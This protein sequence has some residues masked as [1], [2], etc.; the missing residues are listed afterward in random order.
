[1][2]NYFADFPVVDYRFGD[3]ETFTKFQHL[4]TAV[5]ILEQV[6][7]YEVYYETY[8]IQNGERPEV[9][10]YKLYE[11]TNFYWTFY[12]LNDHLRQSGWPLRDAAVWDYVQIYYPNTVI[13]TPAVTQP[14]TPKLIDTGNEILIQWVSSGPQVPL[15][16]SKEFVAGGYLWFEFSKQVGK[17]IRVDH[18]TGF[19]FTDAKD[20]RGTGVEPIVQVISKDDYELFLGSNGEITPRSPSA[21]AEIIKTY[22]EYDAPHHWEDTEGNW[23]YPTPS[24]VYPY[25][26]DH[27]KLRGWS[28]SERKWYTASTKPSVNSVSYGQKIVEL[29]ERQKTISVI[30]RDSIEQVVTEFNRL[31]RQ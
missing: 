14:K 24:P 27:E 22:A 1:M 18:Q 2:S 15:A 3:E 30:K 26:V 21:E 13:V 11:D 16:Q 9:L 5:D 20:I 23:I 12:L 7:Q 8:E 19:I 4:G 31:L 6:K 29:N 28:S 17:I 25:G 10:S